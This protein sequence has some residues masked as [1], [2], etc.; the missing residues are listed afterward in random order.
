MSPKHTTYS[1][2][3]IQCCCFFLLFSTSYINYTDD[4][5]LAAFC[6]VCIQELHKHP[7]SN[8]LGQALLGAPYFNMCLVLPA[9]NKRIVL[10]LPVTFG[11]GQYPPHS[12]SHIP[13]RFACTPCVRMYIIIHVSSFL[14]WSSNGYL[15]FQLHLRQYHHLTNSSRFQVSTELH[16]NKYFLSK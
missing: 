14:H 3:T 2:D 12:Q 15:E 13:E 7:P 5:C 10:R 9:L 11:T 16:R 4:V 6:A 1:E 8:T